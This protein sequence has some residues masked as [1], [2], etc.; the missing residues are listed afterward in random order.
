MNLTD[1]V[2]TTM[3]TFEDSSLHLE[4]VGE[5]SLEDDSQTEE[6]STTLKRRLRKLRFKRIHLVQSKSKI[7]YLMLCLSLGV[8]PKT[9]IPSNRDP[10][11]SDQ[12][13][14]EEM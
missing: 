3:S 1:P 13:Y 11:A 4:G 5:E 14:T 10:K 2:E 12:G 6:G 9:L 8:V 7:W